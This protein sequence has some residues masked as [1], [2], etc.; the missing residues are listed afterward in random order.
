MKL[1]A[2]SIESHDSSA[3]YFDGKKLF[4]HKAERS[5]QLK[6]W[7]QFARI[8]LANGK[9]IPLNTRDNRSFE[10]LKGFWEKE[11]KKIWNISFSDVDHVWFDVQETN[12]IDHHERHAQSINLLNYDDPYDAFV[13]MD[14]LGGDSWWSIFKKDKPETDN[15]YQYGFEEL[16]F[17]EKTFYLYNVSKEHC[18]INFDK[19]RFMFSVKF[20]DGKLSYDE[21]FKW[22]EENNLLENQNINK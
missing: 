17:E 15:T 21:L 20:K 2:I 14:G 13:I 7:P 1:L 9:K 5:L 8:T 12:K 6:R 18:V 4:F 16:I 3:T 19:P 11:V 10:I 22:C